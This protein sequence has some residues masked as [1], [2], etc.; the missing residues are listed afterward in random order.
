MIRDGGKVTATQANK[1]VGWEG[2]YPGVNAAYLKDSGAFSAQESRFARKTQ[3]T[4]VPTCQSH[5]NKCGI[6]SLLIFMM[7]SQRFTT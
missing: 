6:F 5:S 3:H 1:P 7:K 2:N 4:W